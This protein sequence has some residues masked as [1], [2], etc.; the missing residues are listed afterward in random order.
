MPI[1]EELKDWFYGTK[2]PP[3]EPTK[4]GVPPAAVAEKP[5][6]IPSQP[7]KEVSPFDD[8][9]SHLNWSFDTHPSSSEWDAQWRFTYNET[10]NQLNKAKAGDIDAEGIQTAIGSLKR[11]IELDNEQVQLARSGGDR[12]K[13]EY[14]GIAS[15]GYSKT[16][17]LLESYLPSEDELEPKV[18]SKWKDVWDMFRLGASEM[19]HGSSQYF[20][21]VLP[22]VLWKEATPP[23]NATPKQIEMVERSN[24]KSAEMKALFNTQYEDAEQKHQDWLAEHPELK[25]RKEWEKGTIE[26]I[27]ENPSVLLDKAYLAFI[28]AESASFT[29]AFLGTSLAVTGITGNPFLGLMGGV[30]ATTP[31]QSMDLYN[32]L[33]TSGA[34]EEQAAELSLPIGALISSIEVVGGIPILGTISKPFRDILMRNVKREVARVTVRELAKRGLRTFT[35]IELAEIM[36]EIVQGLIQDVTVKTFDKNR[37][38]LENIPE[39]AV[40]TAIASL[41]FGTAGGVATASRGL[42][43]GEVTPEQVAPEVVA[44][45]AEEI[46]PV[47]PEVPTEA[48]IPPVTPP[49]VEAISSEDTAVTEITGKPPK[50]PKDFDKIG[51]GLYDKFRKQAP[52]PVP[53]IVP[54]SGRFKRARAKVEQVTT[55][56]LARL[57]KLGWQAEL[58][59]ATVRA[60]QNTTDQLYKETM[61]SVIKAIGNKDELVSYVDDYLMLR[62]QLEVLKATGK[63]YFTIKKGDTSVRFTAKQIG[64]L[65]AQ[66][67]KELGVTEYAKVKEA[68]GFAPAVYNQLLR[69]SQELTPE[70]IEGLIKKYPWYNPVLFEE[71]T[72][73][74]N[75][76]SKLTP[77]QVKK[78]TTLDYNKEQITPLTALPTTLKRRGLAQAVN[79]AR[80][81]IS[82]LAADPKNASYIGGKVEI[83]T[84]KPRGGFIDYFD[85]GQRKYLK[86]GKGT[87]WIA[88]DIEMLQSRPTNIVSLFARALQSPSKMAFTTYNLGFVA[89]NTF[90]DGMVSHSTEGISPIAFSKA[91]IDNIKSKFVDVESVNAFRRGGGGMEGLFE[92]GN[93]DKSFISQKKGRIVIRNPESLK[94]FFNPFEIIRTLGV[95]AENAARKATVEKALAEGVSPKE[96]NLRGMRVTVD[97]GRFSVASR[98]LNDY[99]LYFNP[100]LQGFLLP[101][102]AIAK[103]PR[104]LW[105]FGYLLA[106]YAA[107]VAYNLSYDEYDD[108][109]D[110]D[111][112]GKLM[113]MLPS[114]EYNK[115]GQKIPHYITMLPL[116]EFA[117]LTA[118][119]EYIMGRMKTDEPE[120][121]RSIAQELGALT[122]IISPLSM[123][124]ET[125][126]V[127]PTQVGS[128][129]MQI[130][131][132]HDDFRNKPIIDDEMK[133]LPVS[134]Q[135][136]QYTN[137]LAIR[138][139]QALNMS[140]KKLDFFVSNLFG[141][142]G[143]D[144][145]MT[146]DNAIQT[147]DKEMIDKR[148]AGLVTELRSIPGTVPPDQIA[149]KRED[150]L[151]K[152]S[153]EDRT[154]VLNMERLPDEQIPFITS[155]FQRFFR[156]Y[157]G[158]V[159]R[160]AKEKALDN[161]TLE[162]Y[163]LPALETLQK[164]AVDN[165]NNLLNKKITNYQYDQARVRYRAYYSGG[166][167]A[168]W[169]EA[170]IEGGVSKADLDKYMPEAYQRSGEFQAVS[171]YMGIRQKYIE[172][173]TGILDSDTWDKIEK[174]TLKDMKSHYSKEEI[175]YALEHK[176]DWIDNLPEPARSLERQRAA[177]LENGTW[178]IDYRGQGTKSTQGLSVEDYVPQ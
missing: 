126:L 29:L 86:L 100:A 64:L 105:R 163:P 60:S 63:K 9:I 69:S 117:M 119:I 167:T 33:V 85:K 70:Q 73:F 111:K 104:N 125:G 49:T 147:V 61:K 3:K 112:V 171:A 165:A 15:R 50:P 20:R 118:P 28:A 84:K 88:Q 116:R 107:L 55:D 110:H 127:M 22:N 59:A 129:V 175:K 1:N 169:R 166:S 178:F 74:I 57:N 157:G 134:Q 18:E 75:I 45:T 102:R 172:E 138:V 11:A 144:A 173:A 10:V 17:D 108:V 2:E 153:V 139:G 160:T 123:I 148:I 177:A 66:M 93:V 95:A 62:R 170:M 38:L 16:I 142:L 149:V 174:S 40:R 124:S 78:L 133:L 79:E 34:S 37:D 80:K 65:F 4:K 46:T 48:V 158:Q 143:N 87:E 5:A 115:Y 122:P 47:V 39:T 53:S 27:K 145:L 159:Y 6:V 58:D 103:N 146:V 81:S 121:Y 14:Y 35:M 136:D 156:D 32:D 8:A 154:L 68:A 23:K 113:V 54:K 51:K 155:I 162:E 42:A 130:A 7:A 106:F 25:P 41:F 67:K 24:K 90:F 150:F 168:Q 19:G 43:A 101:G 109:S 71:D 96:A 128:T 114:D 89:Y 141:A 176:D 135:Y 91:F 140:P 77:S 120:A 98:F 152:L 36:E 52:D 12:E 99:F 97:F 26:T 164:E 92:K 44:P 56:E 13:A 76:N 21:K 151:E 161:R 132:N 137:K 30:G 94:R 82:E 131:R 72:A 31:A 83:V